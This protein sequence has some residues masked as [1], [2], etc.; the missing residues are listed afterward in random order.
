MLA[1]MHTPAKKT[2]RNPN[3]QDAM[4]TYTRGWG[5][6]SAI[7]E[8]A[9]RFLTLTFT[10]EAKARGR[11]PLHVSQPAHSLHRCVEE[12]GAAEAARLSR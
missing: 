8:I 2:R 4:R 3:S 5:A 6:G 11:G 10:H 7:K 1:P 9:A 12:K